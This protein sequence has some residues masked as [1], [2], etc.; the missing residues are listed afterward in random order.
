MGCWTEKEV[1][2][3]KVGVGRVVVDRR[4]GVLGL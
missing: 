4:K 3:G 1:F 2:P